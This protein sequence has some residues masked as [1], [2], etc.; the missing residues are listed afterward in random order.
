MRR[1]LVAVLLFLLHLDISLMLTQSSENFRFQLLVCSTMAIFVCLQLAWV[2]CLN[3]PWE[4]MLKLCLLV[5]C[6]ALIMVIYHQLQHDDDE[7]SHFKNFIVF[8]IALFLGLGL[9]KILLW[10]I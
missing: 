9:F 1:K 3:F 10:V 5:E 4:G 8:N 7:M 6:L 2:W